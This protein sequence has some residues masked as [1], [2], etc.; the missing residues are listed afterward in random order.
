MPFFSGYLDLG[1][2]TCQI[3]GM[4]RIPADHDSPFGFATLTG[5]SKGMPIATDGRKANLANSLKGTGVGGDPLAPE[6]MTT[7]YTAKL[8]KARTFAANNANQPFEE[9]VAAL[10]D[11]LGVATAPAAVPVA[12]LPAAA[13]PTVVYR[14]SGSV[15][16]EGDGAKVAWK[17][18][19]YLIVHASGEVAHVV[20]WKV[21]KQKF[22]RVERWGETEVVQ[23]F[24]VSDGKADQ[25]VL[26]ALSGDEDGN[27]GRAQLLMGK[28]VANTQFGGTKQAPVKA[29]I[30]TS[31]KGTYQAATSDDGNATRASGTMAAKLD[32]TYTYPANDQEQDLD[33]VL[34]AILANLQDHQPE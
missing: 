17:Y 30:A 1:G 28:I 32:K 8:D 22:Y 12:V 18:T 29:A 3:W 2:R 13:A 20:T 19:G 26:A 16:T 5:A 33:Q 15:T 9:T 25:Q 10:A 27:S 31:L 23:S 21:G 14:T 7:S 24:V 11:E 4:A 6:Y 34:A